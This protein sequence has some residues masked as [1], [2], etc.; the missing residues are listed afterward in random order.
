MTTI[1][2]KQTEWH[3][4]HESDEPLPALPPL[5]D[6]S[7]WAY[8][9]P[10]PRYAPKPEEPK[11][12]VTC[13]YPYQPK[14]DHCGESGIIFHEPNDFWN[15]DLAELLLRLGQKVIQG[16]QRDEWLSMKEVAALCRRYRL[17]W[18]GGSTKAIRLEPVIKEYLDKQ[19][20][21]KGGGVMVEY[22]T[23][24]DEDKHRDVPFLKFRRLY[25]DGLC[26]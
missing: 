25:P 24:F 13:K 3:I 14:P 8:P 12:K 5:P 17:K 19:G 7:G 23:E 11:C 22:K 16:D 21:I 26:H 2:V 20:D 15:I 9:K 10:V 4:Q 18:Q 6:T 1:T